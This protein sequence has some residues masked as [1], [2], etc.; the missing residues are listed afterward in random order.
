[1]MANTDWDSSILDHILDDNEDWFDALSDLC[2]DFTSSLIDEFGDYRG[3]RLVNHLLA[4]AYMDH[5]VS[6]AKDVIYTAHVQEIKFRN[7]D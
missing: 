3:W 1:M 6:K 4:N 7:P 2:D 5:K